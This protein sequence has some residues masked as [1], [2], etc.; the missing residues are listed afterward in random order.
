M[1]SLLGGCA[2]SGAVA[3][4]E[5]KPG[6]SGLAPSAEPALSTAPVE[7]ALS[8]GLEAIG[9]PMPASPS[10][11]CGKPKRAGG[12]LR[13]RAGRLQTPVLLTLPPAYDGARPVPLVFAFH[14]RTRSHQAM[15]ETD[16]SGL[17]AAL[18]GG[19]AVAYVKSLGPGFD[20]PREQRENL[21]LFD[22]LYAQLLADY[23][24][25]GEQVFALGHSS[26]GL[27]SE[28][29]A[30]ERAPLLRGIAAVAG[31]MVWPECSGRSAALLVHGER[32]S[33]VSISRG[34]AAREHFR[35]AN[36]CSEKTSPLATPGCV[37]YAGC[38]ASLPVEWCEHGEATY[39]NTNHGWPAFASSEVARF[40]GSLGRVPRAAGSAL[41]GNESFDAGHEPWQVTFAGAAQ[42]TWRTKDGALCATLERAGENPWDAQLAYSGLKP[43]PGRTMIIDYRLWTSAPSDVRIKL[44]LSAA[45]WSELWMQ[46]VEATPAP[47]RVTDRFVLSEPIDGELSLGFQ[48]AGLYARQVPVTLCIDEVS[49]TLA[50]AAPES[51]PAPAGGAGPSAPRGVPGGAGAE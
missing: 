36:G 48:F 5:P 29:L 10:G 50:P 23:C 33:V 46:N 49:V 39:Q 14:G 34:R 8:S 32:D 43:A 9:R 35:V 25:D 41:I 6:G 40:F 17:A 26:G 19:Y 42:G 38:E 45:P 2:S 47:R 31:A 20:Q 30:C 12:A 13:A 11:G 22:A 16:A 27:F 1:L 21:Q 44:G 28:L 4:T 24:I 3:S 51:A 7:P 15:F 18:G 37:Q